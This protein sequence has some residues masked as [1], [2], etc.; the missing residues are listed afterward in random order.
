MGGI[1]LFK[2][3]YITAALCLLLAAPAAASASDYSLVVNGTAIFSDAAPVVE[4]SKVLV[5]LRAVAEA[6]GASVQYVDTE[7]ELI[8]YRPGLEVTLWLDNYSGYKNGSPLVLTSPPK[9]INDRTFVTREQL[10]QLL[11][12]KAYLNVQANTLEV[13]S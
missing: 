6:I 8:I 9:L 4:G 1:I 11:D 10:D 2:M 13:Q 12:V 7:R 3:L 5:P